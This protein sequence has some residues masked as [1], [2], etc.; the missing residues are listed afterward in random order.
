LPGG[1]A[2]ML[3]SGTLA[4]TTAVLA[5]STIAARAA[6]VA[7]DLLRVRDRPTVQTHRGLAAMPTTSRSGTSFT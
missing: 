1:T 5:G 7:A 4:G 6:P 2:V 3:G